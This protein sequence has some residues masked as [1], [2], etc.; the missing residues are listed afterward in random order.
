MIYLGKKLYNYKAKQKK[1]F[2]LQDEDYDYFC[3][4]NNSPDKE[5]KKKNNLDKNNNGED[6]INNWEN[7]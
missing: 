3:N 2:E 1:P 5:N 6:S 7:N 4:S